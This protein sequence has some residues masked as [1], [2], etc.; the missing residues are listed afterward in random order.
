MNKPNFSGIFKNIRN[1]VA[2]HSPEI[3]IGA[4]IAGMVSAVVLAVKATPKALVLIEEKKNEERVDKLS[5]IETVSAAW[6]C[7]IPAAAVCVL[8]AGCIICGNS[9][10]TK[11]NVALAAAYQL[12]ESAFKEYSEKVTETIGEH[13][14]QKIRDDIAKD[15]IDRNPVRN[16][17][18]ILTRTGNVLCYDVVSGRYFHSDINKLK[19]AENDLN[20]QMRDDTYISLNEFYYEIGLDPISIGDDIGWNIDHGYIDLTFSSQLDIN[21]TPCLVMSYSIAPRYDYR[22]LIT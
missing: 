20:R 15:T 5:V 17:E 16:T 14:E 10:H 4:G 19:K 7:Y 13:K 21:G 9:V 8:S 12:S 3:L 1:S 18:I 11:R 6:K 22:Y 2:K